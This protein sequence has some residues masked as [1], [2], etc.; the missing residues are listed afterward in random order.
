ME[1]ALGGGECFVGSGRVDEQLDL[2]AH[3]LEA[4]RLHHDVLVDVTGG[5]LTTRTGGACAA[6]SCAWLAAAICDCRRRSELGRSPSAASRAAA[7]RRSAP[8]TLLALLERG[9][10]G[11]LSEPLATHGRAPIATQVRKKTKSARATEYRRPTW[12]VIVSA[13]SW[14]SSPWP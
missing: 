6:A 7:R 12:L 4:P 14:S 3:R 8:H 5:R 9:E 11:S 2:R 1:L 10:R 13:V